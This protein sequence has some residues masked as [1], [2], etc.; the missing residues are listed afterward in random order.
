[1]NR[2]TGAVSP[3]RRDGVNYPTPFYYSPSF[4]VG[5][6]IE[7]DDEILLPNNEV[8]NPPVGDRPDA[9]SGRGVLV[10]KKWIRKKVKILLLEEVVEEE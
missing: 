7:Q 4:C 9:L 6:R 8:P 5:K 2:I 1:M 10:A 3:S